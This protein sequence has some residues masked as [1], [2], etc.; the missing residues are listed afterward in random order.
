VWCLCVQEKRLIAGNGGGG[1]QGGDFGCTVDELKTLMEHR[2]HE[3]HEKILSD[4][5]SV[6][7]ICKRLRSSPNEG[8]FLI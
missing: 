6:Q 4:Y 7:E 2:G 3:A 1:G 8:Q 5:G